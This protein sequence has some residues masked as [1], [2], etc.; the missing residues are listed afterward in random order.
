[1]NN[2]HFPI[3]GLK[4]AHQ[5]KIISI[6][7]KQAN[8]K[9]AWLFGSRAIGTY[10]NSSDIDL[11]IEGSELT[12]SDLEKIL[13]EIELTS[14]PYKVDLLIKHKISNVDLLAHIDNYAVRWI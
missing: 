1:M 7:Q 4:T 5:Q 2:T 14:I 11:V 10:K 6:I 13:T 3:N 9:S 12:L 8:V